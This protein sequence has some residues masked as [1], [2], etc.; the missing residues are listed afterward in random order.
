MLYQGIYIIG[1]DIL[2][3]LK[4]F[5]FGFFFF[6]FSLFLVLLSVVPFNLMHHHTHHKSSD[7]FRGS[8]EMEYYVSVVDFSLSFACVEASY[9]GPL[10]ASYNT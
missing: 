7:V 1:N 5:F 3:I 4:V 10:V 8:C 6:F 2:R 9:M